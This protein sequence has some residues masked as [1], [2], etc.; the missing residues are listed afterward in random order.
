MDAV[1]SNKV[2]IDVYDSSK[3][4]VMLSCIIDIALNVPLNF[5]IATAVSI[6]NQETTPIK[7]NNFIPD[8][9]FDRRFP[10]RI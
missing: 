1:N 9:V 6:A 5:L 8:H 2:S 7:R 10:A 3:N 4:N